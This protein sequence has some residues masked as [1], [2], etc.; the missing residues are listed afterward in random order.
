MRN[1]FWA[2]LIAIA[3]GCLALI[4]RAALPEQPWLAAVLF[5]WAIGL[6]LFATLGLAHDRGLLSRVALRMRRHSPMGPAATQTA[7]GKTPANPAARV[8]VPRPAGPAGPVPVLQKQPKSV[9]MA[10]RRRKE[11]ARRVPS[12]RSDQCLL[13][14]ATR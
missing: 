8:Q 5:Y 10:R 14:R 13:F 6:A 11:K 3:V 7:D 4:A 1:S 9:P 12:S 2:C